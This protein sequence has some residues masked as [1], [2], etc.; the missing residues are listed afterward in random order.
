MDYRNTD[1]GLTALMT[2]A[3]HGMMEHVEQLITIGADPG[4]KGPGEMTAIDL[5]YKEGHSDVANLLIAQR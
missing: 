3:A 5:A 4:V 1:T 2:C